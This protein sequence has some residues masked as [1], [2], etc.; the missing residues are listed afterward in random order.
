MEGTPAYYNGRNLSQY[1]KDKFRAYIYAN[2]GDRKLVN[3]WNEF[4]QHMQTGLWFANKEDI[5][6]TESQLKEDVNPKK[7]NKK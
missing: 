3:S 2:N 1:D 7:S 5:K 6:D 4:E